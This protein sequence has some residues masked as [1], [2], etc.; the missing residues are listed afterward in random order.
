MLSGKEER[1]RRSG[2]DT[3]EVFVRVSPLPLALII[4]SMGPLVELPYVV[5]T[6]SAFPSSLFVEGEVK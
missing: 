2:D 4:I 6:F 5:I 1:S 3:Q